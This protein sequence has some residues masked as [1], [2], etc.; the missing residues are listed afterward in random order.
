MAGGRKSTEPTEPTRLDW[1]I[2]MQRIAG[3]PLTA[4]EIAMF[5]MFE[6]EGWSEERREAHMRAWLGQARRS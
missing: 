1:A 5:E 3:N 2:A 6:G 4:D